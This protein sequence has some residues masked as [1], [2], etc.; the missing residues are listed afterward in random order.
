MTVNFIVNGPLK[1]PTISK[2]I[3]KKRKMFVDSSTFWKNEQAKEI[4]SRKG[5]YIF[6]SASGTGYTPLYVGKTN[7]SFKTECFQAHKKTKLDEFLKN[8]GKSSLWVFFIVLERT[9]DYMDEI[10]ACE[11]LLIQKCKRANPDLLNVRKLKEP[12]SIEGIH[13]TKN[14]GKPTLAV[15]KLKKC[16]NLNQ[17]REK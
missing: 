4:A 1:I 7:K 5:C 11:S 13:G 3:R 17:M 14:L 10:D 8:V 2:I 9:K 6:A 15:R 16:L 12:F